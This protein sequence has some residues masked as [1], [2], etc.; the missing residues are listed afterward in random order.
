MKKLLLSLVAVSAL[1]FTTQAQTEQGKFMI[2]GN[3]ELNTNKTSGAKKTDFNFAV[4]PSV[5]YFVSDNFAVGTG[6]G[7]SYAK[8]YSTTASV[9]NNAFEV[10]P[11]AR[12]YKGISDEFKFFGQLSVPMTFGNTKVG[13]AEGNNMVKT[14]NNNQVGVALSPGFAFFPSKKIGIEFSV[15]GISYNDNRLE[16]ADG[17]K[18]GGSK[19]FSVGANFFAPKLGVQ[20]YL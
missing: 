7:Y 13:D 19:N 9:K 3:V 15:R 17:D 6:I 20:F 8:I 16:N 1:A 5:G 18:V 11:F 14:G 10:S 12:A 4:I 2:G